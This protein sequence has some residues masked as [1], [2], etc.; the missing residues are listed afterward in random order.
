MYKSNHHEIRTQWNQTMTIDGYWLTS[1][2]LLLRSPCFTS[3]KNNDVTDSAY[4]YRVIA[5]FD[6]GCLEEF[7]DVHHVWYDSWTRLVVVAVLCGF[8]S[9][10]VSARL[11]RLTVKLDDERDEQRKQYTQEDLASQRHCLL[12]TFINFT[13]PQLVW[14]SNCTK[15]QH[16][17]A[18]YRNHSAKYPT[19][20]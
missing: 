14:N 3:H 13:N 9:N 19:N 1:T 10:F 18:N 20:K 5:E 15:L 7:D 12:L 11:R 8:W 4:N 17:Y 6:N 16:Y 2:V